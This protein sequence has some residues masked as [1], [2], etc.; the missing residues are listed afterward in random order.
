[1]MWKLDRVSI[2]VVLRDQTI[3]K[4]PSLSAWAERKHI[5]FNRKRKIETGRVVFKASMLWQKVHY[6][7]FDFLAAAAAASIFPS[8]F[9]IFF[10]FV[11]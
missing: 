1:M 10:L 3:M 11:I 7:I 5:L 9:S 2:P 6:G 8:S 4:S